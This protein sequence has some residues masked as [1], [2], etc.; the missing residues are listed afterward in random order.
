MN[1]LTGT[2][3]QLLG[4]A[5]MGQGNNT[6]GLLP[7]EGEIDLEGLLEQLGDQTSQ[8]ADGEFSGL[9][10]QLI[11][12]DKQSTKT[13]ENSTIDIESEEPIDIDHQQEDLTAAIEEGLLSLGIPHEHIKE[14]IASRIP[15]PQ[16]ETQPA[17][18][19]VETGQLQ[20]TSDI[21]NQE[22][23]YRGN[24]AQQSLAKILHTEVS[25][26]SF[27]AIGREKGK[28]THDNSHH[29]ALGSRASTNESLTVKD[30]AKVPIENIPEGYEESRFSDA[31]I[32]FSN[33]SEQVNNSTENIYPI[34]NDLNTSRIETEPLLQQTL[35]GSNGTQVNL[36]VDA[37]NSDVEFQ[38]SQESSATDTVDKSEFISKPQ[39]DSIKNHLQ[40]DEQKIVN[41]D[42]LSKESFSQESFLN[43]VKSP[44]AGASEKILKHE[45]L[46]AQSPEESNALEQLA[47]KQ[48]IAEP[49]MKQKIKPEFTSKIETLSAVRYSSQHPPSNEKIPAQK[50]LN[51]INTGKISKPDDEHNEMK[52]TLDSNHIESIESSVNTSTK[53]SLNRDNE[54]S[55]RFDDSMAISAEAPQ[56]DLSADNSFFRPQAHEINIGKAAT[57]TTGQTIASQASQGV[58]AGLEQATANGQATVNMI[59]NPEE[60]GTVRVQLTHI[61]NSELGHANLHARMVV[62]TTEA[63]DMLVEKMDTLKQTL[64]EQNVQ[65]DN[66][67]IVVADSQSTSKQGQEQRQQSNQQYQHGQQHSQDGHGS[68]TGNHQ[69]QAEKEHAFNEA[70]KRHQQQHEFRKWISSRESTLNNV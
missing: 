43:E 45:Q 11:T 64:G 31:A 60:L 68:N 27:Q 33:N 44:R 19:I 57:P 28:E 52:L 26:Q 23:N 39:A 41:K 2:L 8:L 12:A 30:L 14:I 3:N 7:F 32:D 4:F 54:P 59:L 21:L 51:A 70:M 38:S 25:P 62:S 17:F 36:S 13:T 15:Y 63:H 58:S 66:L 46:P 65:L 6:D 10:K 20:L 34:E 37:D 55:H 47:I 1:S 9:F 48:T 18:D 49:E 24:E 35:M 16:H 40:Q 5:T 56:Y 29:V 22:Q 69:Q 53:V 61:K 50:D 67:S 42:D